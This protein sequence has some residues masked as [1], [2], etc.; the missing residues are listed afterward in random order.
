MGLYYVGVLGSGYRFLLP[1]IKRDEQYV[2]ED[3]MADVNTA[4]Y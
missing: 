1:K 4:T 3:K 2:N